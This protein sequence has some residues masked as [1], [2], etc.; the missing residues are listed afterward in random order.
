VNL[1]P[2]QLARDAV[3]QVVE[4]AL[5]AAGLDGRRL[6]LELTESTLVSDPVRTAQ[7][8]RALKGLGVSLAMDD[9][10]TGYSN[11]AYLQQLPIDVLKID[12]SFVL[13]MAADRDKLAIVRAVLSLAQALGMQTVAEG[14]E[15]AELARMLG[16]LGCHYGQGFHFARPLT[17]EDAYALVAPPSA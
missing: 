4:R 2:V 12:R 3:V 10:G 6:K 15:T 11:L 16:A 17:A 5:G 13:N 8:L 14:I 1:S 7:T 9:F